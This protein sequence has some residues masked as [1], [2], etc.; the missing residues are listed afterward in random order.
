MKRKI[1]I[2][3]LYFLLPL[4]FF[5]LIAYASQVED[6]WF[7]FSHGKYVLEHGI[8]HTDFLTI[9]QNL[10]FVMQ[11]WGFSVIIYFFYHHLGSMGV[12]FLLGFI[13]LLIIYFLYRLCMIHSSNN[14]YYSCLFASVIDVILELAFIIPRPQIISML[15]FIIT[16][17]LL[18]RHYYDSLDKKIV[19]LPLLSILLINTHASMWPMLFV[20]CIPYIIEYLILFF[21]KKDKKIITL[22]ICLII[23]FICGFLNPYGFEA[24]TYSI[25][26]YGIPIANELIIEMHYFT[27][28]TS[29]YSLFC[30]SLFILCIIIANIIFCIKNYKHNSIHYYLLFLG[31][32][33]M[34]L[35]NIRN[36]S[37]LIIG[38]MPFF[39]SVCHREINKEISY[40]LFI[41]P[42]V[43]ILS[44]IIFQYQR[45]FYKIKNT[46]INKLIECLDHENRQDIILYTGFNEG[47]YAEYHGYSVYMD[48]RMEVFLKK[49]NQK[50]DILEEYYS[51]LMGKIDYKQ[52]IQKYHF[53]Y[54]IVP[55]HTAFSQYLEENE[56]EIICHEKDMLLLKEK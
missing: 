23:S 48:S 38:T 22:L 28:H 45:N 1:Y 50:E 18:E 14:R 55:K 49:N 53:N 12:F 40:K 47:A 24:M 9:H 39:V 3:Y 6:I 13:N 20:I 46:S 29:D 8:P 25:R 34:A 10:H 51:V 56:Y 4:F 5:T 11:Q 44:I 52:F 30:N 2:G 36:C 43:I 32:S 35:L 54:F 16:L 17:F 31:L 41:I 37:F 15:L 19:F 27:L 42:I 33:F 21:K 26:S 7:L